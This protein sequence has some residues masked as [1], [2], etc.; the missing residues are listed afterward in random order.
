MASHVREQIASAVLT[1]LTGLATTGANVFR[2]RDTE[3]NPLQAAELPGLVLVDDGD[4]SE[5]VTLGNSRALERKL[6]L[7][8]DAYVKAGSGAGTTLNQILKEVEVA[9]AAAPL[10][11]A[12]SANLAEV[13]AREASESAETPTLRQR[14]TFQLTYYTFHDA[15][16]VAL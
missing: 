9:L 1:A 7:S 2:D 11:G 3:G 6:A 10:G 14:F 16:D 8:I 4:P 15:P 12:K 13:A 5:V